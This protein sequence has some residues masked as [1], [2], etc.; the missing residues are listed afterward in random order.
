R[1]RHVTRV[2][3]LWG[4]WYRPGD[5]WQLPRDRE[6][7]VRPESPLHDLWR[8]WLAIH[9]LPGL[10]PRVRNRGRVRPGSRA[11]GGSRWLVVLRLLRIAALVTDQERWAISLC[12]LSCFLFA[13]RPHWTPSVASSSAVV[14]PLLVGGQ[15]DE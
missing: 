9:R 1:T 5:L 14:G 15:F 8:E 13:G 7:H 10:P 2:P 6:K 3:T 12:A 4:E 11:A